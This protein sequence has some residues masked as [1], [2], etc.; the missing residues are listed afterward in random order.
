MVLLHCTCMVVAANKMEYVFCY[1][2]DAK[3][4]RW[5]LTV[6]VVMLRAGL[7]RT[8]FFHPQ[9]QI[10]DAQTCIMQIKFLRSKLND[11]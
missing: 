5:H 2:G 11:Q 9:L 10:N 4:M 8:N 1:R 6:M 7:C 3:L